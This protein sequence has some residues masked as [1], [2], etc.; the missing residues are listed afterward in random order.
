ML[1]LVLLV[2]L[3]AVLYQVWRYVKAQNTWH[4]EHP[5]MGERRWW[6]R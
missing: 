6:N 2:T 1:T 3:G 4:E 5:G